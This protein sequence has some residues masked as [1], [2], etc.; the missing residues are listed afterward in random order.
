[1]PIGKTVRTLDLSIIIVTHNSYPDLVECV[2]SIQQNLSGFSYEIIVVD[3]FSMDQER[4]GRELSGRPNL[5]FIPC[6]QNLGFASANNIGIRHASGAALLMLNP[7]T[8]VTKGTIEHLLRRIKGD[9]SIGIIGPLITN[10]RGQVDPYC[11]RHFPGLWSEFLAQ[12]GLAAR[13]S[14]NRVMN[15]YLA[16]IR[17]IKTARIV[18]LLSGAFMMTNRTAMNNV[19][20]MDE[21]F[22]L[23]GDDVE[24]CF[25]FR[26]AGYGVYF[27]PSVKIVHKGGT[28]IGRGS[29]ISFLISLDSMYKFFRFHRGAIYAMLYRLSIFLTHGL[30]GF[31]FWS[32]RGGRF[33]RFYRPVLWSLGTLKFQISPVGKPGWRGV[34]T[35]KS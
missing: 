24:W 12:T 22:F 3:N 26:Q 14:G 4:M 27:D 28:S 19:G 25:R 30:K 9:S 5:R 32:F 13:F 29:D 31:F 10:E 21:R 34:Q 2:E 6:R 1:M 16:E 15:R 18:N 20:L 23:Y 33:N 8:I 17:D 7:D 35:V 11:A